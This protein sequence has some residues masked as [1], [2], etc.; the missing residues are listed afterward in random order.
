MSTGC[1]ESVVWQDERE[2]WVVL[3]PIDFIAENALWQNERKKLV[4][5]VVLMAI[6]FFTLCHAKQKQKQAGRGSGPASGP[7]SSD[8]RKAL[9]ITRRGAMRTFP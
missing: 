2:E 4:V 6:D 1:P 3:K 5:V 9:S 8:D 7:E